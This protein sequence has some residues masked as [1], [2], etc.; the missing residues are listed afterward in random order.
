MQVTI[1]VNIPMIA[2]LS[3]I[4][5]PVVMF[6]SVV[7]TNN[8]EKTVE[9][10]KILRNKRSDKVVRLYTVASPYMRKEPGTGA[11]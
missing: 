11:F 1:N 9:L 6:R 3:I 4:M 5:I 10:R 8:I 2:L 7:E